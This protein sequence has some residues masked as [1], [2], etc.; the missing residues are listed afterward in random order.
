MPCAGHRGS[1]RAGGGA[2]PDDDVA[3]GRV[4][5]SHGEARRA[6]GSFE[7]AYRLVTWLAWVPNLIAAAIWI[8]R[9]EDAALR[10]RTALPSPAPVP[11]G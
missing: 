10:N 4:D 8:R 6:F 7:P 9:T 2:D 1:R 3:N 5:R 11:R